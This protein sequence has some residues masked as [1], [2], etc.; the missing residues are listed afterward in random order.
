MRPRAGSTY[1]FRSADPEME[2]VR[3]EFIQVTGDV[4]PFDPFDSWDPTLFTVEIIGSMTLSDLLQLS[5]AMVDLLAPDATLQ[6]VY[7]ASDGGTLAPVSMLD[8]EGITGNDQS[9]ITF[10]RTSKG[11]P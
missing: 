2:P 5:G 7:S 11:Q 10:N 9:S 8:E 6:A 1:E 4:D 3:I